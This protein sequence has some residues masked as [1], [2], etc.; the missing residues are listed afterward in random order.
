MSVIST[1]HSL[2]YFWGGGDKPVTPSSVIESLTSKEVPRQCL[3]SQCSNGEPS[4][5][6]QARLHLWQLW[7]A[8]IVVTCWTYLN[9]PCSYTYTKELSLTAAVPFR[10]ILMASNA[11]WVKIVSVSPCLRGRAWLR[12]QVP[13]GSHSGNMS[14]HAL[15]SL[16][17]CHINY[18]H[19]SFSDTGPPLHGVSFNSEPTHPHAG[20]WVV[21][22]P[23]PGS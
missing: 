23:S 21:I 2:S 13:P 17:A 6:V 11:N 1:E 7:E 4:C 20:F 12:P 19:Y 16:F 10:Y 14:P 5:T 18:Q 22:D 9:T 8:E 15:L 3:D